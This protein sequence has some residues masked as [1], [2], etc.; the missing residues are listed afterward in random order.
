MFTATCTVVNYL[1]AG[2]I[3][4]PW[5]FSGGTLLTCVILGAVVLQTY[6]TASFV[7]ESLGRKRSS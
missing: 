4:L 7:L 6:I 1:A 5:A 2:Y 3:L